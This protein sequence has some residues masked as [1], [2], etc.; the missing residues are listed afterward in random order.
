[1]QYMFIP[2]GFQIRNFLNTKMIFPTYDLLEITITFEGAFFKTFWITLIQ[3][4]NLIDRYSPKKWL[5][6]FWG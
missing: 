4:K 1:M 3:K 5:F 2:R 6:V